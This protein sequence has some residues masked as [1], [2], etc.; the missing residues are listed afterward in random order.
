M[1]QRSPCV[2]QVKTAQSVS[3]LTAPLLDMEEALRP[4]ALS[5]SWDPSK[6]S[7]APKAGPKASPSQGTDA[8]APEPAAA[9][10]PKPADAASPEPAVVDAPKPAA[11]DAFEP[12][13]IDAPEAA[14]VNAP[15]P[16]D[17]EAAKPVAA[18]AEKARPLVSTAL[19]PPARW[20]DP[21]LLQRGR[22][23]FQFLSDSAQLLRAQSLS[24]RIVLSLTILLSAFNAKL[25]RHSPTCASESMAPVPD[26]P[27][28]RSD[29]TYMVHIL[30][31][32]FDVCFALVWL[33]VAKEIRVDAFKGYHPCGVK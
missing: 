17:V 30:E 26:H 14:A 12:A 23:L 25:V 28:K 16:A 13:A 27:S 7:K 18:G 6:H 5:A 10:A 20:V 29:V 2:L 4:I 8:A 21:D 19:R 33:H 15:K 31:G 11:I 32:D 22:P 24:L 3:Q 9:D 1:Q